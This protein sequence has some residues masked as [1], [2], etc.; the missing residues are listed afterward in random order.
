MIQQ[1]VMECAANFEHALELVMKNEL[2]PTDMRIL[3]NFSRRSDD[4][5]S[6]H[7][8]NLWKSIKLTLQYY[9]EAEASI[10]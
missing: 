4:L 10:D 9:R 3:A 6:Y 5:L 8:I 2:C 1:T 7:G